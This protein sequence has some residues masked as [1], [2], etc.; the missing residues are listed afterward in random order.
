[1]TVPV[2]RCLLLQ[3]PQLAVIMVSA[4]FVKP[5][6]NNMERLYFHV[7]DLRGRHKGV[8]GLFQLYK[9]LNSAYSFDA[10][11][12]LHNV[13]RTKILKL[14]FSFSRKP[15][16]VIDKGRKEKKELTRLHHKN[17]QPLKPTFQRY[18][19]VFAELG[20]A[21]ELKKEQ[22][23]SKISMPEEFVALKSQDSFII[24]IA[25]FALHQEKTYPSEKMKEVIRLLALHRS[26]KIFLFGSKTDSTTLEQ[27]QNE[28][29]TVQSLAGKINFEDELNYI[30]NLDIMVSMDSANMHL[31][32]MFGVPV[33]SIWGG[34]HP[35]LGFF[36]WGQFL[37]NAVQIDLECRPSSVFGNKPCKNNRACL[38]LISPIVVYKKIIDQL[39]VQ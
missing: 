28:F 5:L 39:P 26:I 38:N 35:Y 30:G 16:A 25:P 11:A 21:I 24:G 19:D 36:G 9:E 3:H 6:F 12:D 7:A 14:F 15:F 22:G 23:I 32:S 34:T 8:H 29:D 4:E 31:A 2:I 18:A 37:S 33:V 13:L 1:M 10:V 17:L 27:W 20:F